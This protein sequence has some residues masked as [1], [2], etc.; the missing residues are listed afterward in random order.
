MVLGM[1]AYALTIIKS[2]LAN[3]RSFAAAPAGGG[4]AWNSE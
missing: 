3:L 4:R 1:A 2:T